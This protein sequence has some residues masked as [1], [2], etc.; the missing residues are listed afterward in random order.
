MIAIIIY[1]IVFIII[2]YVLYLGIDAVIRG[3]NA[4]ESLNKKKTKSKKK[5]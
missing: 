3:L 2:S 1:I 5:N 4:K